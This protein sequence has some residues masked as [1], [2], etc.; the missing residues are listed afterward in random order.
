M[1]LGADV[2]K[3]AGVDEREGDGDVDGMVMVMVM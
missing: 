1:E 2:D 3:E